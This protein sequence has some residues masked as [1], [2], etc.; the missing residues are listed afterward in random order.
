MKTHL[1]NNT[2][3]AIMQYFES[4]KGNKN[5]TYKMYEFIYL[6]SKKNL[7]F[8]I[9]NKKEILFLKE[10]TDKIKIIIDNK[11][12]R[13]YDFNNFKEYKETNCVIDTS[14]IKNLWK[15]KKLL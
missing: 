10:N 8:K 11:D 6:N 15:I 9:L 1:E 13:I 2:P 5:E 12:G 7:A 3:F 14:N 4:F